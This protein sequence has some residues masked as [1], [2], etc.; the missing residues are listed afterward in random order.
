MPRNTP[1]PAVMS[2]AAGSMAHPIGHGGTT[3]STWRRPGLIRRA[4]SVGTGMTG[5][6]FQLEPGW[7]DTR[8]KMDIWQAGTAPRDSRHVR[9]PAMTN[10]SATPSR[11]PHRSRGPQAANDRPGWAELGHAGEA[12]QLAA[13]E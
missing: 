11:D 12:M 6:H 5:Y 8:A 10:A 2:T 9:I 4:L 13:F 1:Q 7:F 3:L